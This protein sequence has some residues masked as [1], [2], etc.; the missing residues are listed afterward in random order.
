M[1]GTTIKRTRVYL[2]K[3][4]NY[5]ENTVASGTAKGGDRWLPYPKGERSDSSSPEL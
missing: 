2:D 1:V 5:R 4:V 3:V